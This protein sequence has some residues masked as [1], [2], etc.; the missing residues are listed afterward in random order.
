MSIM[1]LLKL[2]YAAHG[3]ALATLNRPLIADRIEAWKYGPVIPTVYYAF[4]RQ[5]VYNLSEITVYP[6]GLE[7][8]IEK[9]IRDTYML[10][11]E[12]SDMQ[13]SRATHVRNG[14]WD[15]AFSNDGEFS[16]IPDS[17]IRAH[18]LDKVARPDAR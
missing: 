12:N 6:R 18:Y 2:V 9:L 8:E 14:P 5:G 4:R 13:L 1:R 17:L 16:E 7:P 11:R 15:L 10:Y 3:W